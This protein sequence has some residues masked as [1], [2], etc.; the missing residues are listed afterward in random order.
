M[1]W[2]SFLSIARKEVLHMMRDAGTLRFAVIMPIFQL[3][4]FGSIDQTVKNLPTVVVDQ[5][6]STASREIIDGLRASGTLAI[7]RVTSN[8]HEARD[9]MAA[10]TARVGVVIPPDFHDATA[11]GSGAE[12]LVLASPMLV[13]C[14]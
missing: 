1:F 13:I 6:R 4:L 5:D 12:L 7:E 10:G 3:A 8:E 14:A 2:N 11:R 9:Q